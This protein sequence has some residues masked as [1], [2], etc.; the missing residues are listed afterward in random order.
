MD[1]NRLATNKAE[2]AVEPAYGWDLNPRAPSGTDP[3]PKKDTIPTY[4]R[5]SKATVD[6]KDDRLLKSEEVVWRTM[7]GNRLLCEIDPTDSTVTVG[8][9]MLV[10]AKLSGREVWLD[11]AHLV[12]AAYRATVTAIDKAKE[13]EDAELEPFW[14]AEANDAFAVGKTVTLDRAADGVLATGSGPGDVALV[15]SGTYP[16]VA[17]VK[18]RA[19]PTQS[20]PFS[21]VVRIGETAVALSPVSAK[22]VATAHVEAAAAKGFDRPVPA[23]DIWT[24]LVTVTDE[25]I[26]DNLP[27]DF[28]PDSLSDDQIV[29]VSPEGMGKLY[30]AQ[31]GSWLAGDQTAKGVELRERSMRLG[32]MT[33]GLRMG[34]NIY[35][36][37]TARGTGVE[38]HEALHLLSSNV[39]QSVL[40]WDFNEGVT[41]YFTRRILKQV[42][43]VVRDPD[44]YGPQLAGVDALVT[45][46]L[47]TPKALATAYFK[48]R[49]APLFHAVEQNSALR[50]KFSLQG[51]AHRLDADHSSAA[52]RYLGA[53]L[54]GP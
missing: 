2:D 44:T 35:V 45:A 16:I 28:G 23:V 34:K 46:N 40:G 38:Y 10:A 31:I 4:R 8:G 1:P 5:S 49:V 53:A 9:K 52:R 22:G 32:Q 41:E 15:Q 13:H 54:S 36:K 42:T 12:D 6:D 14:T 11:R 47:V 3:A 20:A 37:Q 18:W 30:V 21:V 19:D 50:G 29:Y 17:H 33:A 27:T 48:G 24:A 51:Y 39:V 43:E 26:T 7:L 25:T